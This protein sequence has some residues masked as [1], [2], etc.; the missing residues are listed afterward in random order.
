MTYEERRA[1]WEKR[2]EDILTEIVSEKS[3]HGLRIGVNVI[4]VLNEF[5]RCLSDLETSRSAD[6]YVILPS[7][8]YP[9]TGA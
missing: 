5:N 9:F 8:Q 4:P 1:S 6:K 3:I 7:L 2:M